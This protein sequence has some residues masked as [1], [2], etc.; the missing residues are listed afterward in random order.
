[1]LSI[2][3]TVIWARTI[4][5]NQPLDVNNLEPGVTDANVILS[6]ILGP[7]FIWRFNR[8]NFSF[9]VDP[10]LG[11]DYQL[12][13]ANL[14]RIEKRW[15]KDAT[16]RISEVTGEV[17][18]APVSA[19]NRPTMMAPVY[20]DNQGNITFRLN[21][22]PDKPYTLFFD[23][24][25]KAT[26]IT[27]YAQPWGVVPDEFNYI[28]NLGFLMMGGWITNDARF[29]IWEQYFVSALLGAQD[30]L[31]AQAIDIFL[32]EFLRAATTAQRRQGDAQGGIAGRQK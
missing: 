14:G 7:P 24:Q 20:D 31:D 16:D 26:L 17:H 11:C 18:M 2:E 9:A 10:D 13:V 27:S 4:L 12:N 25:R 23:Y 5:K 15:L 19:L 29:P 28:F 3:N 32:G 21:Y 30:G 22:V 8:S 6:R 1:M